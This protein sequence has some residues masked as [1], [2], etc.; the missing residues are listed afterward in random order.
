SAVHLSVASLCVLCAMQ[1][2]A[3]R[4][5]GRF[6]HF[7]RTKEHVMWATQFQRGEIEVERRLQFFAV[8]G[9]TAQELL[10]VFSLLVPSGQKRAGEIKTFP[11]PTL[12]DHVDLLADL[13]LVNLF[14]LLGVGNI[15]DAALAV[16]EGIDK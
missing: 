16:T 13:F 5:G 12:R 15:E 10:V 7:R 1:S 11:V 8:P 4:H 14:R 2:I 6:A 9:V 3:A